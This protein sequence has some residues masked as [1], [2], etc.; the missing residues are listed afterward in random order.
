MLL[1]L[2]GRKTCFSM[3][4]LWLGSLLCLGTRFGYTKGSVPGKKITKK[5]FAEERVKSWCGAFRTKAEV[6]RRWWL[7]HPGAKLLH[8][9][10]A[11][12]GRLWNRSS[13]SAESV[14]VWENWSAVLSCSLSHVFPFFRWPHPSFRPARVDCFL[15]LWRPPLDPHHLSEHS[16]C[17]QPAHRVFRAHPADGADP[18]VCEGP[19]GLQKE[20]ESLSLQ[21]T[22]HQQD[23]Q[24]LS[25]RR[26]WRLPSTVFKTASERPAG[27]YDASG[28]LNREEPLRAPGADTLWSCGSTRGG[29]QQA[30]WWTQSSQCIQRDWTGSGQTGSGFA[31]GHGIR[32]APL[33]PR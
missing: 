18:L 19:P 20:E 11:D 30:V 2:Q 26:W 13:D 7:C 6:N 23:C 29:N 24:G 31:S 25:W 17:S 33:H 9:K 27:S 8:E 10:A 15:D 16:Y 12:L 4:A 28:T 1:M 21:W 5:S 22:P 3:T 32:S 14:Y